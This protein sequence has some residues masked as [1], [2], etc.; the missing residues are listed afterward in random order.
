MAR[1]QRLSEIQIA[2]LFDPPTEQ[3][4]LVRYYTLSEADLAAVARCRGDHNRLGLALMRCYLRYPGRALQ[5]GERPPMAVL[6]FVAEQISVFPASIDEY[7]ANERNR[8]RQAIECQGQAGLRYFGKHAAAELAQALLPHAMEDDRLA[9]LAALTLEACRQRRIICPSPLALERLCAEL[10]HQGRREVY[11]RLTNGLSAD[12]RKRLDALTERRDET[13]QVWLT[14]LRQMPEAATP[15]AM[16][17]VIERLEHV[18][19]VGI[20]PSRGHLIHQARLSQLAREADKT[21][22]QHVARFERQRRHA[23]LVAITL[24]FTA[25]LTD[26]AI[27][28]FDRLVGGIF[29]KA[30]G[31]HARA[32]QADARA[33]NEKV[34]L[35]A[36]VGAAL[37]TAQ[38]D[39]QDAFGAIK[40]VIPWERFCKTVAEAEALARPEEFD[41]FQNLGEHY[42][43]IRRWSPAFLSAF[44]FESVP[45]SASL[46]RAIEVL[47]DM[48]SKDTAALPKSVPT[49]FVRQRWAAYVMP[50]GVIDRR[51]YELCV[52]SEL[53]DRLRS[54]DV[55]VTGSRQYRSVEE[56][57][58]SKQTFQELQSAGTVPVAVEADFDKF[59]E[60]RRELLDKRLT[61]VNSRAKDGLLPGVTIEKGALKITPIEKSTPPEAEALAARLY[62]MLPRIR[63]TDLL[64]EVARWTLFPDCFT[65][66][67]TG[68]IAA[69]SRVLMAGL[70]AEGLNLGLT[71]MAEACSI[72]SLGQLAWTSDWHIRDETYASALKCLVSQQEREPFAATFGSSSV[73]SSDGQFFQAAGFGRDAALLNAHYSQRSGFKVYTHLSGRYGPY[74]TKLIAATASEALHVLDALVY[75]QGDITIRRHH[76]DGGGDSDHV[77]ALCTL[78]GFVFA[79]RI[80]DLKHRRLYSFGKPS[81][82]PTLEPLIAGRIN[83]ELIR[84]H[85]AEILRIVASIRAGTVAPSVIMRQLASYPR[86]NGVA[87]ALRELGRLERTLFTLDWIQDPELRRETGQELNKG[88]SRNSLARAVFIHRLGEIRDRTYEN[89]QH[90][91]SGLN[92]IVTAIILWNT[93]YLERAVATL[94]QTE[95][96]PDHLLAHLS[97]LGWEHINLT[98]DYIWIA[99]QEASENNDGLRPL[100][101]PP[102][103]L[104]KAA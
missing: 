39:Q 96:V 69:D 95:N 81:D 9:H 84:A 35:Y 91:A 93:R 86:Q 42:A 101:T 64:A 77:F 74:F 50:G 4:E 1:R 70:L 15:I 90:R 54:G 25:S 28:H 7:L 53:R 60:G 36:R 49:G 97:P 16:L 82:Y 68:E 83:V 89:Q 78:L 104:R 62:A 75:H 43:G 67:R 103:V 17:G 8:Q 30:E 6:E 40:S 99:P 44:A 47:R 88:E 46:L 21:T 73:S 56:R 26:Q 100:R 37:I 19:A 72:A 61:Q 58:I 65:H 57:L 27:D 24:D 12:Q 10:R 66:L 94:R 38:T 31:R 18:R 71:R 52:L 2:E 33:I 20:D 85:W 80:P 32:F 11:R 92:L 5:V 45:A 3:R 59:I 29:R 98:G 63:V 79:P 55:W 34:R 102:E 22:V 14:W 51:H 48:N 13:G 76:T 41:A 23:T 87:A